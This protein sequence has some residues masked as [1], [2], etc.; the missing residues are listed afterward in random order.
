MKFT[1]VVALLLASSLTNAIT[2]ESL[3]KLREEPPKVAPAQA[4]QAPAKNETK[5]VNQ[6]PQAPAKLAS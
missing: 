1:S 6:A 5:S 2:L 3:F 4:P